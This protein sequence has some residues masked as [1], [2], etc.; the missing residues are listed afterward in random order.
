[1]ECFVFLLSAGDV[2]GGGDGG[3]LYF[4]SIPL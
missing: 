1:M 3:R 4:L 2:Y